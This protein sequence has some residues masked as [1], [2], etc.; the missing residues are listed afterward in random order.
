MNSK[1]EFSQDDVIDGA[2]AEFGKMLK[3]RHALMR[4]I[5]QDYYRGDKPVAVQAFDNANALLEHAFRSLCIAAEW[6]PNMPKPKREG[7][8]SDY[9][10]RYRELIRT[11][12]PAEFSR[13]V[14]G[15][16][17]APEEG[18]GDE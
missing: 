12:P 5:A 14:L 9:Y 7:A 16:W 3:N 2:L 10:L 6:E 1:Q 11:L 4:Q 13:L 15:E 8:L 18:A 17:V